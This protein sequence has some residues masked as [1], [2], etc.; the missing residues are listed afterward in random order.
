MRWRGS[1]P[2]CHC[3]AGRAPKSGKLIDEEL[4]PYST[5]DQIALSGSEVQL[6]PATAQTVALALHELVTNSAKYG[7]LS[8]LS[9]RLS[10][11][12]EDQ[13]GLLDDRMGGD[14]RTSGRETGIARVRNTKRDRQHRVAARRT[15][16]V[17]LAARRS[18][19]PSF[20]APG[21]THRAIRPSPPHDAAADGKAGR[22]TAQTARP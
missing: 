6:Q 12:W 1:I 19:L 8:T 21:S 10:V 13:A 15:G 9:G 7:A 4:A 14:R 20:R 16:R 5:G 11:S 18:H 22:R 17:R 2:C 3:R